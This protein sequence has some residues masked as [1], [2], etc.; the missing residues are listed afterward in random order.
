M[1]FA[2]KLKTFIQG[3]LVNGAGGIDLAEDDDLLLSGLVDSMGVIR[4]VAF[5]E[6]EWG[7]PVPPEDVTIDHFLT[8]RA[9][10]GYLEARQAVQP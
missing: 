9:I 3:E 6:Q 1:D 5:I 10:S 2:Q 8:I 7:L 4:L